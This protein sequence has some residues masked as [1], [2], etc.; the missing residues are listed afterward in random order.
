MVTETNHAGEHIVEELGSPQFCREEVT[1]VSGQDL[2]AGTVVGKITASGKYAVYD[3][4]A[5]DG[6][7]TAAGVLFDAV[8]AS[9]GDAA[10]VIT[11]RGAVVNADLLTSNDANG[12]ADLA[13]LNPPIIV[14]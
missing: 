12:T 10:G 7:Q 2:A 14:R 11:A 1:I 3:N 8:D 4:G 6:T 5:A 13:A 9:G